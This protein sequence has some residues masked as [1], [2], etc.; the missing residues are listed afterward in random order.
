MLAPW[1]QLLAVIGDSANLASIALH[2]EL[3]FTHVG[4]AHGAGFKLGH[5]VDIARSRRV[6]V[7]VRPSGW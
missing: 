3:G 2:R 4:T 5:W 7:R 1:R 6:R